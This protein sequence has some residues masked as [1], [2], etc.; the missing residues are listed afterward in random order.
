MRRAIAFVFIITFECF[1][2]R[3][4]VALSPV[5]FW[6]KDGIVPVEY[7]HQNIF[8]SPATG[9]LL[10]RYQEQGADTVKR[11]ALGNQ[12]DPDYSVSVSKVGTQYSY[13]YRI[14][15]KPGAKAR[16]SGILVGLGEHD[17][18]LAMQS[19]SAASLKENQA[20]THFGVP[21]KS[22]PL[23]LAVKHQLSPAEVGPDSLDLAIKS[24]LRPG[25]VFI[26]AESAI[27]EAA[28]VRVLSELP[29]TLGSQ[30]REKIN[31]PWFHKQSLTLGPRFGD[32]A[33]PQA[34]AIDYLTNITR[35]TRAGIL[36]K[37]SPLVGYTT[38][39]LDAFVQSQ[40]SV[41]FPAGLQEIAPKAATSFEREI[42]SAL[43]MSFDRN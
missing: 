43:L 14:N 16:L 15:N 28:N 22:S 33:T 10:I 19:S 34:I 37:S 35:L 11:I 24:Q 41:T 7:E 13:A 3:P 21:A 2:Q 32:L 38:G 8:Y 36:Q 18:T 23:L 5:P 25:F 26:T 1:A 42:A 9:E 39:I 20:L 40:G 4:Q 29:P 6:P 27:D 12:A 31:S 30:V 17:P